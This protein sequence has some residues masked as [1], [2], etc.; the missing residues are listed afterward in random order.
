MN[1]VLL[2]DDGDIEREAMA[3]LFHGRSWTWNWWIWRGM[4]LK[5]LEKYGCIFLTL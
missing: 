2:V 4:E 3:R 1:K 5:G